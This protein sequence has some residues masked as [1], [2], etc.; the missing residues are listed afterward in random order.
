MV[1][2]SLP[3]AFVGISQTDIDPLLCVDEENE[4]LLVIIMSPL[5][6]DL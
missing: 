6:A 2:E 4:A 1:L 5:D 3:Y